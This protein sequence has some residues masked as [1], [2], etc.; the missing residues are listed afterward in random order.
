M[1][2]CF[3]FFFF[4]FILSFNSCSFKRVALNS[5]AQLLDKGSKTFYEEPDPLLAEET[6]GS[7]LKFLEVLLKNDPDHLSLIVQAVQGFGAYAF[8]FVEEKSPERAIGFYDRGLKIGLRA[9]ENKC[10]ELLLSQTDQTHFKKSLQKLKKKD[11]PLLFWTSYSW[12]GFVNLSLG[13]SEALSHLPK[14]VSMMERV[15]ELDP[16][17]FYGG[18]DLFFGVYYASRPSLL[19][20]NLEQ[21]KFYF[22][23]ALYASNHHFLMTSLLYAQTY[24]VAKQDRELYKN[25]LEEIIHF[26]LE[27]FPEQILSNTIAKERAEKLLENIDEH[28]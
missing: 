8:L 25:L 7:Q 19:G 11:V 24:A 2:N 4:S 21:S 18:A 16:N 5:M 1:G 13:S 12:A 22:N 15:N 27:R 9:L 28:F 23:R 20:G 14:I 3:K 10:G 17:Y 26:P 6:I